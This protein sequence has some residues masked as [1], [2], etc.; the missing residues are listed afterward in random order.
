MYGVREVGRN[1]GWDGYVAVIGTPHN[2][3][4]LAGFV[5]LQQAQS[6]LIKNCK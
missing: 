1:S 4:M 6:V 5:G 3:P 2:Y